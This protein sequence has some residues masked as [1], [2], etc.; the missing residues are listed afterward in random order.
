MSP[1]E[2]LSKLNAVQNLDVLS[3]DTSP[4]PNTIICMHTFPKMMLAIGVAMLV[5]FS[6]QAFCFDEAAKMYDIK[7]EGPRI[8][9]AL[10][11]HESRMQPATVARNSNGTLDIG[12]MG[13]NTVHLSASEAFGQAGMTPQ[14]LLDPCTNVMAGAYLLKR[15]INKYGMSWQ[16]IGAYHSE[17]PQYA[18]VYANRIW[19]T[20]RFTQ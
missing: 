13:I 9:R 17:N 18:T 12:L 2:N 11:K 19:E 20:L 3:R 6:A 15:K 14:M 16:A 7:P 4:R 8:L 1:C 10:A 5:S